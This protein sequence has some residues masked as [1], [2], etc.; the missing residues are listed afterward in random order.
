MNSKRWFSIF[1]SVLTFQSAQSQSNSFFFPLK[2]GNTWQYNIYNV[3]DPFHPG[4][5]QLKIVGDTLMPNNHPYKV[6]KGGIFPIY[7]RLD[8]TRVYEY[9]TQYSLEFLKYD[10]S[11]NVGDT[12]S[13]ISSGG[14]VMKTFDKMDSV[15]NES[16]K[17]RIMGFSSTNGWVSDLVVDS[18][19]M[20]RFNTFETDIVY[21]LLGAKIDN[22]T[23][24]TLLRVG[25]NEK[26]V[27]NELTLFQNYPNP[28]NSST[29][30]KFEL[31]DR[32][33]TLL[34]IY[35]LLGQAIAKLVDGPK[36]PGRY[37]V[38]WNASA[39]P[40]GVYLYSLKVGNHF[41]TKTLIVL[42]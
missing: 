29:V 11:K 31:S 30:I 26:T 12:I 23:Y 14:Y 28:F 13:V 32:A 20:L 38:Q 24:G 9:Y 7:L 16:Q 10:F 22:H 21:V 37:S 34:S 6:L 3:L 25:N 15:F 40:S 18:I 1:L 35:N 2:E 39:F 33:Y 19:G 5:A 42:K 8:S 36:E 17:R 41:K 27:P 4:F